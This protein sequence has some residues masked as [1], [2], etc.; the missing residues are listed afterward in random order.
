MRRLTI[1]LSLVASLFC[2]SGCD[3]QDIDVQ[4]LGQT[5]SFTIGTNGEIIE[6]NLKG[7]T[8]YFYEVM[9][10]KFPFTLLDTVLNC[11]DWFTGTEEWAW[12][13]TL[14]PMVIAGTDIYVDI[15]PFKD[16][17]LF[18]RAL[19]VILFDCWLCMWS[20]R[21]LAGLK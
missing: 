5:Q 10:T 3:M 7:F 19:I 9:R 20:V 2:V 8:G 13:W 18:L 12:D 6:Y 11:V 15:R 17:F 1:L 16:T 4:W 21:S 14:G